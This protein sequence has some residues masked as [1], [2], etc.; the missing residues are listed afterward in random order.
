M[1]LFEAKEAK[2]GPELDALIAE[3]LGIPLADYS[4]ISAN[5]LEI[6]F[7]TKGKQIDGGIYDGLE[8]KLWWWPER[9][10]WIVDV[11]E[12]G[13]WSKRASAGTLALAICRAYL[14]TRAT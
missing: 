8:W 3:A 5:A 1:N 14:M 12:Y 13:E 2:A 11:T 10:C 4:T 7:L 9:E 6:I